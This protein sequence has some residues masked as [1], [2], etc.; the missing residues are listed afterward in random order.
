[1][2]DLEPVR[3]AV[4]FRHLRPLA[5]IRGDLEDA[6]MRDVDDPEIAVSVEARPL[7]EPVGRL[8]ALV[9]VAP[10][11]A[12]LLAEAVGHAAEDGRLDA[13]RRRKEA[14]PI[15]GVHMAVRARPSR[16]WRSTWRAR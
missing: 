8:A 15:L 16:A 10:D 14:H 4:I 7:E 6:A 1:T 3:L 9:G 11:G 12:P 5:A 13:A 2:A